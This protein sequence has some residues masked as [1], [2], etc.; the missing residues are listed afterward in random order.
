[1]ITPSPYD[2]GTAYAAVNRYK[3]GDMTP[4]I[5]KT[6]D[7]GASWMLTT[8]GIPTGAFARVV[9][10]DPFRKGLLY[11][12][13]EQG[14]FTSFDAGSTW[15]RFRL[16][17]PV[18]P[19]HDLV[20][21][22]T[23]KDLVICTHG[24]S[25]WILDDLTPL[26]QYTPPTQKLLSAYSPRHSYRIAGGS[27]STPTMNVGENAPSGVRLYYALSDT[28]T[29]ELRITIRTESG[30]SIIAFSSAST[31]KGE[32]LKIDRS[33]HVDSLHRFSSEAPTLLRGLNMFTWNMRWPDAEEL[34]GA[35]LWGGGTEGPLAVPGRY[36]ATFT[37]GD[38]SETVP[39]EIRMDPRLDTPRED[40]VAQFELH[41]QINTK[42]SEVNKAIKRIREVRSIVANVK[43]SW[44]DLDS[45]QTKGID[46]LVKHIS[47][48]LTTVEDALIQTKA[49]AFQ[50]LL[51]YPVKLNNKIASLASVASS[52]DRRPTK[53]TYDLFAQLTKEADGHLQQVYAVDEK[54]ILEL[55][56]RIKQLDLPVIPKNKSPKK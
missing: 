35:L 46:S 45:S 8:Q 5:Y 1:M 30:D 21:H 55:N 19:V 2:A 14:L 32:P 22:P 42:L 50:D 38:Q 3:H 6:T 51:N 13:T 56:A 48:T 47:D 44:A 23:E 28:T 52:A 20:V 18:T 39:F 7:Y 54:M 34:E 29:K 9:R 24:R 27:W 26:H 43:A 33:F 36:T 49:K 31:P 11:A 25:F 4:Y 41:Q 12:G 15:S 53:Q 37:L 40:L 16:N 10:E 17:F